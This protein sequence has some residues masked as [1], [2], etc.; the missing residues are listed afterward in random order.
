MY[1][2]DYSSLDDV[3]ELVQSLNQAGKALSEEGI[4][5]LYHNHNVELQKVTPIKQLTTLLLKKHILHMLISSLIVTG[6][7]MAG[8]M[9]RL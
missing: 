8:L 2:F 6:W 4:H 5:L 9:F 3:E 7:P 1:K